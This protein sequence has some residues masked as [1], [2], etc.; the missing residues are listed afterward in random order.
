MEKLE[1]TEAALKEQLDRAE[2]AAILANATEPRARSACYDRT[3]GN[4]VI[5]LKDSSTFMFPHHLGQGLANA[6][7]DEEAVEFLI[8]SAKAKIWKHVFH[9]ETTAIAQAE[10]Y[11]GDSYSDRVRTEFLDEYHRP[12]NLE[13]P[14]GYAFRIDG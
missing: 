6:S 11:T 1:F 14:T 3:S 12:K 13:I 9:D 10:A 7:A 4:I 5:H 2:A 8:A